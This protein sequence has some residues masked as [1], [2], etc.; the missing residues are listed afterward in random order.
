MEDNSKLILYLTA[1]MVAAGLVFFRQLKT[2][3]MGTGLS[4]AYLLNLWIIH[5]VASTLYLLPEYKYYYREDVIAGL[6]QSAYAIVAFSLSYLIFSR[7][8]ARAP[9]SAFP[10]AIGGPGASARPPVQPAQ[11][12]AA[13]RTAIIPIP[14]GPI[15]QGPIPQG[16]IPQG[17]IP[18]GPGG[19][20]QSSPAGDETPVTEVSDAR[21]TNTYILIGGTCYLLSLTPLGSLPTITALITSASNL[22]LVGLMI[23]SWR[24][25]QQG[26]RNSFRL[27][28]ML[29]SVYPLLTI[30]T[31]GFLGFGIFNVILV[32]TFVAGFYRPRWKLIV[33]GLASIY[34]G[35]SIYVTY[36]RDRND[37][38]ST[39]WGGESYG[40]RIDQMKETFSNPEFF[41][42]NEDEH[43]ERIDNRLN[44]NWMVG[45][46][47]NQ[48]QSKR[49]EFAKGETLLLALSAFV[50]RVI[51]PNK[52]AMAGSGDLVSRFTGYYFADGT[53]VGVGQVM[54][55][56]INFGQGGVVAGFLVIGF[57]LALVDKKA[58]DCFAKNDWLDFGCWYLP[59]AA[60]MH[61][62]GSL[63]EVT[64]SA[65]A[66]IAVS[67]L[68]KYFL[69]RKRKAGGIK[70]A[71]WSAKAG[72][73]SFP[74]APTQNSAS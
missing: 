39:V 16:P 1:W 29:A 70:Q 38:R 61:V 62:G 71:A 42:L 7:V 69:L 26:D 55:F 59:G 56:Y 41:S 5:W 31:Q 49:V 3:S 18:Q 40:S 43:L 52:P 45:A 57:I 68:V 13:Y 74:K 14:Q 8:L 19:G 6:E 34:L 73:Q 33:I 25:W 9:K 23:K 66:A 60:L 10:K 37:I 32:V 30:V 63:V 36:M 48:L 50:P 12:G 64:A 15:P 58:G 11:S 28:V 27:W 67:R 35:L 44:Q 22:A 65:G 47:V 21:L 2:K 54:E 4:L 72:S 24:S 46:A 51:W 20:K 53:S 17:P